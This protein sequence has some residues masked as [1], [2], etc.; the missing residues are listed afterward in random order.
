MPFQPCLLTMASATAS[1]MARVSTTGP[2][3]AQPAP[4]TSAPGPS[5]TAETGAQGEYQVTL[6]VPKGAGPGSVLGY[7]TVHSDRF[8]FT[9]VP[10]RLGAGDVLPLG[11]RAATQEAALARDTFVMPLPQAMTEDAMLAGI[12][13]LAPRK[14]KLA[15]WPVLTFRLP[16]PSDGADLEQLP[17]PYMR[18]V[19]VG[20]T[21]MP[22][23]YDPCERGVSYEEFFIL[24]NVAFDEARTGIPAS[25]RYVVLKHKQTK[26]VC[27]SSFQRWRKAQRWRLREPDTFNGRVVNM[28]LEMPRAALPVPRLP[29][30]QIGEPGEPNPMDDVTVPQP[31]APSPLAPPPS[32]ARSKTKSSKKKIR[33][34]K[35][36]AAAPSPVAPPEPNFVLYSSADKARLEQIEREREEEAEQDE[37]TVKLIAMFKQL[38]RDSAMSAA[39]FAERM[40]NHPDRAKG[41]HVLM[42]M[43]RAGLLDTENV[44]AETIEA[45]ELETQSSPV[46]DA[47]S[48]PAPASSPFAPGPSVGSN[49]GDSPARSHLEFETTGHREWYQSRTA[50][51]YCTYTG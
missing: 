2:E 37:N 43:K 10:K 32:M 36:K 51:R 20:D 34:G 24:N 42:H 44:I 4:G 41:E 16:P 3:P 28:I 14:E 7:R 46:G 18:L 5:R 47:A 31:A 45:V 23:A 17:I 8:R 6:V 27:S 26:S 38:Q 33:K 21:P 49:P 19:A 29:K 39:E 22:E 12:P 48:P 40:R 13:F 50:D 35:A 9:V 11:M 15:D 1:P 30:P 25:R